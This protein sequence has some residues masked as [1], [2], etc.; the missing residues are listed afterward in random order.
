MNEKPPT[1]HAIA[2]RA[3]VAVS[4]VS[5]ALRNDPRLPAPTWERIQAIARKLGYRPNPAVAALMTRVRSRRPVV[6]QET[7]AYVVPVPLRYIARQPA[8]VHDLYWQGASERARELGFQFER[9]WAKEEGMNSQRLSAILQTRNIRG[10]LISSGIAPRGHL[11]LDWSKF[12]AAIVGYSIWKPTLH[13]A[14][15]NYFH[16]TMLAL[17]TLKRRGYQRISL[18]MNGLTDER[19]N[20]Q[21]SAA[22][23]VFRDHLPHKQRVDPLPTKRFD[24]DPFVLKHPHLRIKRRTDHR[25]TKSDPSVPPS[26]RQ[27]TG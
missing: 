21:F 8:P 16:C 25:T 3:G 19:I 6:N 15:V 12:A 2:G 26:I 9:V 22:F 14:A 17:R 13:R 10:V 27:L 4:T 18:V 1:L 23:H 11:S 20:H 7:I 5:L 24:F